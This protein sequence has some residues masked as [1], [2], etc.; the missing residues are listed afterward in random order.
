[1]L[2][3]NIKIY[4]HA[5]FFCLSVNIENILASMLWVWV[6]CYSI[7]WAKFSEWMGQIAVNG[8]KRESKTRIEK[9]IVYVTAVVCYS[10]HLPHT[11]IRKYTDKT[12]TTPSTILLHSRIWKYRTNYL[13]TVYCIYCNIHF[14]S[15][16]VFLYILTTK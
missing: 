7:L 1:M 2:K 3:S 5:F 13:R 16:F 6:C 8:R 9:A 4:L 14:S 15:L 10:C 11:K 12:S